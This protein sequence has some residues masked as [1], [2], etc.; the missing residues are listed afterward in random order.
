MWTKFDLLGIIAFIP[1]QPAA[2]YLSLTLRNLGYS[3]FEA[4][5]LAIPGYVLFF[6]NVGSNSNWY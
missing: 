6:I 5:M 4:N 2:N 1:F 3:V